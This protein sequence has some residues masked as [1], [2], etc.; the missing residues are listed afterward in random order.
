[1]SNSDRALSVDDFVRQFADE[2]GLDIRRDGDGPLTVGGDM[3]CNLLH[4]IAEE[5]GIEDT[6][7]ALQNGIGMF[8]VEFSSDAPD[9]DGHSDVGIHVTGWGGT[10]DGQRERF[11]LDIGPKRPFKVEGFIASRSAFNVLH[12]RR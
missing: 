2:Q 7:H 4:W 11:L 12:G 10:P 3:I 6:M 5:I 9:G 1:M 8:A